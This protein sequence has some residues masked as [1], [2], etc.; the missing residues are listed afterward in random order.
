MTKALL[1]RRKRQIAAPRE[2]E[3]EVIIATICLINGKSVKRGRGMSGIH[4]FSDEI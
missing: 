3:A 1:L 4:A 2:E